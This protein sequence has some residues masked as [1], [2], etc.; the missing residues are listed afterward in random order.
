VTLDLKTVMVKRNVMEGYSQTDLIFMFAKSSFSRKNFL[1]PHPN[2]SFW[3]ETARGRGSWSATFVRV[4]FDR[5]T[6]EERDGF[7]EII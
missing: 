7:H 5:K 3:T 1:R 2:L 4:T 6:V